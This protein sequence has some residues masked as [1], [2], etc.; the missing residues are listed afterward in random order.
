MELYSALLRTILCSFCSSSSPKNERTNERT[1]ENEM[2]HA[3]TAKRKRMRHFWRFLACDW[4][5]PV[6]EVKSLS[7]L[8]FIVPLG[9]KEQ[10]NREWEEVVVVERDW[11]NVQPATRQP[12]EQA[13]V[14][15]FRRR[16]RR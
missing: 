16:R 12:D 2:I 15:S 1:N 6:R 8:D 13:N 10:K 11:K 14:A 4:F 9:G 3:E 5:S 7:D